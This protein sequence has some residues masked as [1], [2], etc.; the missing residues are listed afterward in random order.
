M[1]YILMVHGMDLVSFLLTALPIRCF[2]VLCE[3]CP[4]LNTLN[5][6]MIRPDQTTKHGN[7]RESREPPTSGSSNVVAVP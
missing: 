6:T 7:Q 4:A 5:Q 3:Q 1:V 2:L